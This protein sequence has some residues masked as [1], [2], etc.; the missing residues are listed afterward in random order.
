MIAVGTPV[1]YDDGD[2]QVVGHV[3]DCDVLTERIEVRTR[4]GAVWEFTA[5]DIDDGRL[6]VRGPTSSE[7]TSP[8]WE[9]AGIFFSHYPH[10]D[11]MHY[12]KWHQWWSS[13]PCD[14][15]EKGLLFL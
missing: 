13:A 7:L 9:R 3:I 1:R 14:L 6:L 5:D 2:V 8:P 4:F 15:C 12:C 11:R 10:P